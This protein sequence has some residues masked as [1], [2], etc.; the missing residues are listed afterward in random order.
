MN[1]LLDTHAFLW[2][3][4]GD[5]KLSAKAYQ[6]IASRENI[7]YFS[8]AS[9]WEIAIKEKLGKIQID[10][11]LDSFIMEQLQKNDIISLTVQVKH[12]LHTSDLPPLHRDPFD[13]LLIAQ[14]LSE[15]IPII[16]ADKKIKEYQVETYW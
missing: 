8:A 3:I 15:G 16:T 10:G 14:S 5:R 4:N 7:I 6:L 12:A 9:A 1:Y 11:P 13:R 2:W